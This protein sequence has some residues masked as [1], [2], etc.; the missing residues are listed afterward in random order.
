MRSHC[1]FAKEVET[2]GI[3]PASEIAA[4]GPATGLVSVYL[5]PAKNPLT[6]S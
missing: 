5:S 3:E 2:A 6:D 4:E 1:G